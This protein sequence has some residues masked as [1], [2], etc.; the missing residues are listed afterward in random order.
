MQA[1][2]KQGLGLENLKKVELPIPTPKDNEILIKVKAVSLNYR[3]KA[4]FDGIYLPELMSKHNFVPASD[5]AGDVVA[6]GN[7][8]TLFKIGDRVISSLYTEWTDGKPTI[9]YGP[10]A[11]GGP[12][13][14]GLAQYMILKEKA[15]VHAPSYMT[16]Q[17]ASTLPIA[18]LTNWFALVEYGKI[19][20]GDTVLTLGSGGVSIF[21]IQLASALGARVIATTSSDEK[22]QLL[23]KLGATD[24]V[25]YKTNPQWVDQVLKLTNGEGVQHILDVVGDI[26]TSID[27][28]ALQGNIYI[29]GFLK[30]M[31]P[32]IN[33]FNLLAKQARVQGIYVGNTRALHDMAKA[34][35]QLQIKPVIDHVYPFDDAIEAY[36]HLNRGAFGKIV[37]NID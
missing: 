31:C 34:F 18:A 24:I 6:V 25:N 9:D 35:D 37:I 28:V 5:A 20:A 32:E 14:G 21:G 15:V 8:V 27:A 16:Y 17:E 36:Q 7:D 10:T 1:W 12:N 23:K 26:N 11:V 29:I 22:A 13:D 19:K 30:N 2:Q 3:D 4:I 33:L